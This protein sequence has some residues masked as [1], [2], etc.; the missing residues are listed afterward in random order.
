MQSSSSFDTNNLSSLIE[1]VLFWKGE[2][3]SI[4]ELSKA[5]GSSEASINEALNELEGKLKDRGIVLMRNNDE[6]T[7]GTSPAASKLIESITKEELSKD[8]GRAAL[9]TLAIILYKG[10]VKRSEVDYIR[11]VNSTFIIRNL[12]IRGLIQKSQAPNDQRA[13]VYSTSFELLSH[14]G[15]SNVS[16]LPEFNEVQEE[17]RKFKETHAETPPEE[18]TQQT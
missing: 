17:I 16:E 8:L 13:S 3:Q 1:A 2:P 10:P 9:E 7:L 6:V 4:K 18:T 12:L 14:L 5:F 15:L 11:G